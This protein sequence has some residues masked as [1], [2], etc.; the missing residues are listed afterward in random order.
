APFAL[1]AGPLVRGRLV[2][3]G[4]DDHALLLTM[5][6]V[7]SDGWSVGVLARELGGLYA[8]FS[9]GEADP[10]PPLPVPYPDYALWHRRWGG[11][12]AVEAQGAYWA[13]T[14]A[15]APELLELP[16]DRPRPARQDFAGASVKVELDEALTAALKTLSQRHGTTPYMT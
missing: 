3:M 7:V 2:R 10:L 6:H 4:P 12:R 1:A 11:R 5:H 14:L 15:G 16:T 13:E 8:A 9:R